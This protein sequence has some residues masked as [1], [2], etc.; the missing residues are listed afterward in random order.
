M[1]EL[2]LAQSLVEETLRLIQKEGDIR[3]L[4]IEVIFGPLSGVVK[5]CM[6]FCFPEVTRGT[7]LEKTQ[8]LLREVPL[9]AHCLQCQKISS[10]ELPIL[11][12]QFCQSNQIE[13]IQGKEFQIKTLEVES[14]VK[15]ADA[16]K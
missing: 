11:V 8:L 1:H 10:P 16:N 12:C 6:E 2:S 7:P 13:I 4:T 3:V 15:I 14:C 9:K 5:E